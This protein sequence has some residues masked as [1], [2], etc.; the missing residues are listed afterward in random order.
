MLHARLVPGSDSTS[1]RTP[2]KLPSILNETNELFYG[3]SRCSDQGPKSA[4]ADAA[5]GHHHV[6]A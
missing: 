3:H 5:L 4:C 6:I 1:A 2:V